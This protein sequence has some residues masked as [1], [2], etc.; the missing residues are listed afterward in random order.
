LAPDFK[1][2]DQNSNPV[3]LSQFKGQKIVLY[4]YPKDDTPGCTAQACNLRDNYSAL[5]QRGYVVLGVSSDDEI[6]HK[7]FQ[8][9]YALPF[10]LIADTDKSI[11]QKYGV[12]VEKEKEGQKYFGTARTTFLIDETG[13]ITK[14]INQVDTENHTGQILEI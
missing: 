11:N 3:T 2:I 8:T 4:F 6:S 12:W 14:I 5:T 13:Y 1:G 10:T 7:S 9:K